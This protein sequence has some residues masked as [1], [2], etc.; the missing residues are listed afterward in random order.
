M[1]EFDF[2]SIPTFFSPL[3]LL[4]CSIALDADFRCN[5]A[6]TQDSI[7]SYL[8]SHKVAYLCMGNLRAITLHSTQD[9]VV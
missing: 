5:F 4:I 3:Q 1:L 8:S 6:A 9:K 2:G 7:Y